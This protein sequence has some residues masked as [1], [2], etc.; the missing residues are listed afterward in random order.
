MSVK[1]LSVRVGPSLSSGPWGSW[2]SIGSDSKHSFSILRCIGSDPCREH[3]NLLKF[4]VSMNT[5]QIKKPAV[6]QRK[7]SNER[8]I[9]GHPAE[10]G[11]AGPPDPP[12]SSPKNFVNKSRL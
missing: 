9:D 11:G 4:H 1:N 5:R 3:G 8:E 2:F 10:H 7:Y 6:T 12:I